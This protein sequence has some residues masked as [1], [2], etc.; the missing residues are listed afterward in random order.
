[1]KRHLALLLAFC[2]LITSIPFRNTYANGQKEVPQGIVFDF[3]SE[4]LEIKFK[5]NKLTEEQE[6]WM[7]NIISIKLNKQYYYKEG[8]TTGEPN[9]KFRTEDG[10]VIIE[11]HVLVLKNNPVEIVSN[12]YKP[13]KGNIQNKN[14]EKMADGLKITAITKGTSATEPIGTYVGVSLSYE[15][16]SI[17][18]GALNYLL[19]NN[20][21]SVEI[22]GKLLNYRGRDNYAN[23][24][25]QDGLFRTWAQIAEAKDIVE[26]FDNKTSHQF[27]INMV[28]GSK[29]IKTEDGYVDDNKEPRP[30]EKLSQV[31][32]GGM[33]EG[34]EI[35][36]IGTPESLNNALEISSDTP[37]KEWY[38]KYFLNIRY[39][40]VDDNKGDDLRQGFANYF[41]DAKK[42]TSDLTLSKGK[43]EF[44][45]TGLKLLDNRAHKIEIGFKDG[46]TITY[47]QAGYVAPREIKFDVK[48]YIA[49]QDKKQETQPGNENTLAKRFQIERIGFSKNW[50]GEYDY[51]TPKIFFKNLPPKSDMAESNA[52]E[53]AMK[54]ATFQINGGE[55]ITNV[56]GSISRGLT[57]CFEPYTH[58]NEY[59]GPALTKALKEAGE[60]PHIAVTFSDNSKW[61]NKP[62]KSDHEGE[63]PQSGKKDEYPIENIIFRINGNSPQFELVFSSPQKAKEV[64]NEI[65]KIKINGVEFD[66]S[67]FGYSMVT[68]HYISN[69][70]EIG[71]ALYGKRE[72]KVEITF[73]DNTIAT[74]TV[75]IEPVE[76]PNASKPQPESP[77]L[78]TKVDNV[79]GIKAEYMSDVFKEGT[80]FKVEKIGKDKFFEIYKNAPKEIK[81]ADN[82]TAY[83]VSFVNNG[84]EEG[85]FK[86]V[87]LIFPVGDH[88]KSSLALY[89]AY[90]YEDD[91]DQIQTGA[92]KITPT[93]ED[94][95]VKYDTNTFTT[96][97]IISNKL[98]TRTDSATKVKAEF[99]AKA[100]KENTEMKVS[101]AAKDK[102]VNENKAVKDVTSKAKNII[103]YDISFVSGNEK[104]QPTCKV[105]ITLPLGNHE[106]DSLKV[107]HYDKDDT[108]APELVQGVKIDGK[109]IVFEVDKFSYYF[110]TSGVKE[111][112]D[113]RKLNERFAIEAVK[114][115]TSSYGSKSLKIFFKNYPKQNELD[116]QKA[117]AKIIK[118][119]T[120]I[121]NGGEHIKNVEGYCSYGSVNSFDVISD[122]L[123]EAIKNAGENPHIK[124]IFSDGSEWQNRK[125]GETPA[126]TDNFDLKDKLPEGK[127]TIYFTPTKEGLKEKSDMI[128]NFFGDRGL[129]EVKEGKMLLS[130]KAK[131]S[132]NIILDLA[133][134]LGDEFKS[135]ARNK[136][137][138][139][140]DQA[141]FTFEVKDLD[142]VQ[143]LAVLVGA[144]G[145]SKD[146]IGKFDNYRKTDIHFKAP[147]KK[148]FKGYEDTT[149]PEIEKKKNLD[150]LTLKLIKAGVRDLDNDGKLSPEELGKATGK[151]DLSGEKVAKTPDISMLKDLGPGVT[152]IELS[153]NDITEIPAGLFDKMTSISHINIYGNKLETLPKGIFDK[154]ENLS[155]L[156]MSGNKLKDL[157]PQL[158]K[159]N[160]NL[161][162]IDIANNGIEKLPEGFLKNATKLESIFLYENKLTSLDGVMPET[163]KRLKKIVINK[164]EINALPEVFANYKQLE[165]IIAN[166]NKLKTLPKSLDKLEGLIKLDVENNEI[167][168]LPESLW[169]KL[170]ENANKSP[171][172]YPNLIVKGNLLKEVP[173][174]KIAEKASGQRVKFNK[175]DVS[176]N[177]LKPT[178][179]DDELEIIKKAG[180]TIKDTHDNYYQPQR[181]AINAQENYTDGK[182]KVSQELD[183]LQLFY[184]NIGDI[185]DWKFFKSPNEFKEF[186]K[187]KIY[188]KYN[189]RTGNDQLGI[190]Q[191]LDKAGWD[192]KI[193]NI[194][195][196]V[197][198]NKKTVVHDEFI[199]NEGHNGKLSD[200]D[201]LDSLNMEI[202]VALD[203]N[204][205]YRLTRRLMLSKNNFETTFSYFVD[206][207][208][209]EKKV[210]PPEDTELK[211]AKESLK[212]A[213]ESAE[214]RL[215][216]GKE[217]TAESKKAVSEKMQSAKEVLNGSDKAAIKN[218]QKELE[219]AVK[220]LEEKKVVPQEDTELKEAKEALQ[221]AVES[222]EKR[223]NDGK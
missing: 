23:I 48:K 211:E 83:K 159:N 190:A 28:D 101:E 147:I 145:G 222:A 185:N 87:K 29:V 70:E 196:K 208:T 161:K 111:I 218:A 58:S 62:G 150:N 92:D 69:A 193:Q 162:E 39:I 151:L 5:N 173:F 61:D 199:K 120:F 188:N 216:D 91:D 139:K 14:I 115:E 22:D 12:G 144:M 113:T 1:M 187:S 75:N 67:T 213:V 21:R 20:V 142:K 38:N 167:E 82:F 41:I 6:Q 215:D 124:V 51:S 117:L 74:K 15:Y 19:K 94:N 192:W 195:E 57:E 176:C 129:L 138:L 46:N 77:K 30:H 43:L 131:A 210:V 132:E 4:D 136:E 36:G 42:N 214:K 189:V 17:D 90:S 182:V 7:E 85:T 40:L 49:E 27:I 183:M 140:D 203:P 97:A 209:P 174:A 110:V 165:E 78:I 223:L 66:K 141:I 107:Y 55:K 68:D 178:L 93:I 63:V 221:K 171:A 100:F 127:Y 134:K 99:P 212:K 205:N 123:Q 79:T 152:G 158:L 104:Q 53:A 206:F 106:K 137:G 86:N 98:E 175:F 50:K 33:A 184:W 153:S 103:V 108:S 164:N 44:A 135:G 76:D 81:D 163:A 201:P 197:G 202:N 71:K 219:E 8:T 2:L 154:N 122:S 3:S 16:D 37:E 200:I 112:E 84:K 105:K 119:A 172:K 102:F 109:K 31:N 65:N 10:K 73:N 13:Y 52:L 96:Y 168:S 34:L 146:Q 177:Y 47:T 126:K 118:E 169:L 114:Y 80:E 157:D 32:T 88:E 11:N 56:Q 89:Q 95:E 180:V 148:G 149:D 35:T 181:S 45:M 204:A 64:G 160:K 116:A 143:K 9:Y 59:G 24:L 128:S 26:N 133:M 25:W 54:D 207:K 121:V 60:D 166:N 191:V 155:T 72:I 179:A 125:T 198:S 194:I 156:W 220:K 186:V 130:L 217:Y 170:A 18:G